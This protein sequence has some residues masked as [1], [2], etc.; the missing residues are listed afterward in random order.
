M[1]PSYNSRFQIHDAFQSNH[2]GEAI[3][4]NS[5]SKPLYRKEVWTTRIYRAIDAIDGIAINSCLLHSPYVHF[6]AKP[7]ES[8]HFICRL[9]MRS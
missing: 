6:T 1:S 2:P 9:Y 7:K 5:E 3:Q 4:K 8:L